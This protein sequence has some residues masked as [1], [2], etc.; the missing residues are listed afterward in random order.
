MSAGFVV[1][2]IILIISE[3]I[4]GEIEAFA[5]K[6]TLQENK[7]ISKKLINNQAYQKELNDFF[8]QINWVV[9][10]KQIRIVQDPEDNKILESAVEAKAEFLVTSDNLLL[11]IKK[12]RAV[13]IV[14]PAQFWVNYKDE[15]LDFWKSMI[16]FIKK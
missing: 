8:A 10:K 11:E 14:S 9:N 4:S 1:E 16:N 6:Q 15:G 7:L 12:F 13:K 3:F 2:E 5:N